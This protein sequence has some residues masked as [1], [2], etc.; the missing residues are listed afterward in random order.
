MRDRRYQRNEI[1]THVGPILISVNPYQ[2]LPIYTP[3]VSNALFALAVPYSLLLLVCAVQLV[4]LGYAHGRR[5]LTRKQ[6]FCILIGLNSATRI[7]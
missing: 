3:A 1:Y 5:R 2:R 4:R 7:T 6:V